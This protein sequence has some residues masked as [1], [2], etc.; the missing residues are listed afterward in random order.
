MSLDE[1]HAMNSAMYWEVG[2]DV[3]KNAFSTTKA[4]TTDGNMTIIPSVSWEGEFEKDTYIWPDE[5]SISPLQPYKK[6]SPTPYT[7]PW[8]TPPYSVP[9]EEKE[10][11]I[12]IVKKILEQQENRLSDL[13]VEAL[14]VE[15]EVRINKMPQGTNEEIQARIIAK[16][17]LEMIRAM[18]IQ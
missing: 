11:T 8:V 1:I 2:S 6:L 4:S 15:L 3:K 9:T 13:P 12:D 5:D 17:S 16:Q 10:T 7:G 18:L 14:L